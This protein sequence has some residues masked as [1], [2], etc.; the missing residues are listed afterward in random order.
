MKM[1]KTV[2]SIGAGP[3]EIEGR[4]HVM[5]LASCLARFPL[6]KAWRRSRSPGSSCATEAT[7]EAMTK[8]LRIGILKRIKAFVPL[9]G[10]A[11]ILCE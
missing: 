8:R 9:Y 11:E 7:F 3:V 4:G 6:L 1:Q 2:D 10:R 5:I